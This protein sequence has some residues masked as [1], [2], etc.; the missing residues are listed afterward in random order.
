MRR[1]VVTGG[2]GFIGSHLV[3]MIINS[4]D[5]PVVLDKSMDNYHK[6]LS[7]LNKEKFGFI[8][9]DLSEPVNSVLERLIQTSDGVFHLAAQISVQKS[10]NEFN[11]SSRN[12]M[13]STFNV[14]D[15]AFKNRV[16]VIFASSAAVYKSKSSKISENHDI[17]PVSPYGVDKIAGEMYGKTLSSAFNNPF[18]SFRFFNIYGE[19]QDAS[20]PYSGVISKFI[21]MALEGKPLTI[22]GDGKQTRD[23]VYVSDVVS[24]MYFTMDNLSRDDRMMSETFNICTGNST[25]ILELAIL[26]NKL[27]RENKCDIK[28]EKPLVGDIF[29][30]LGDPGKLNNFIKPFGVSIL[31]GLEN[32]INWYKE[33]Q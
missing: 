19:R 4:G 6:N 10:F 18:V 5:F 23:F 7:H 29:A 13:V 28:F 2:A 12:N 31:E 20:S 21:N 30:S 8:C 24:T 32:T 27:V 26:I 17:D 15:I 33:N 1:Y 3:E 25:T 14:F 16:P 22:F 11:A 9:V